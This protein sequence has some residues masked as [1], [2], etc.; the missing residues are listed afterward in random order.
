[1][2]IA[3]RSLDKKTWITLAAG[4]KVTVVGTAELQVQHNESEGRVCVT[5]REAQQMVNDEKSTADELFQKHDVALRAFIVNPDID[6][7]G[8]L[9]ASHVALD[10]LKK[11]LSEDE[12]TAFSQRY[13][14]QV[15][16][17]YAE[18]RA[19]VHLGE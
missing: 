8:A 4:W 6:A 3:K 9:Y 1:L 17:V 7:R 14:D 19:Y 10:K 5:R 16:R 2:P 15:V 13:W 12:L 11:E 18:M